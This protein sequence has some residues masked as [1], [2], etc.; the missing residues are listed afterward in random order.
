[1]E[2]IVDECYQDISDIRVETSTH[3]VSSWTHGRRQHVAVATA[4]AWFE[5]WALIEGYF[6]EVC[7]QSNM[8]LKLTFA[9]VETEWNWHPASHLDP[10]RSIQTVVACPLWPRVFSCDPT[11]VSS[12]SLA[13]KFVWL[14]GYV[15]PVSQ[16]PWIL[17]LWAPI[18]SHL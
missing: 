13:C 3:R 15:Q 17:K 14:Q 5:T 11:K 16:L 7:T 2:M 8:F 9:A 1:L 6:F 18:K 12:W 4:W 10:L